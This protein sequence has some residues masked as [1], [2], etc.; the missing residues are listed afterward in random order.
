MLNWI[1]Q[2]EDT[3]FSLSFFSDVALFVAHADNPIL[4]FGCAD[5]GRE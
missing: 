2:L 3:L 5:D 1:I 4:I